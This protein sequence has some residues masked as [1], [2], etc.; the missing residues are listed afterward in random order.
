M[1]IWWGRGFPYPKGA[2]MI[3]GQ[4]EQPPKSVGPFN[5][6]VIVR[7][8]TALLGVAIVLLLVGILLYVA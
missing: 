3:D 5:I 2:L 6:I 1:K 7:E 8:G 4:K